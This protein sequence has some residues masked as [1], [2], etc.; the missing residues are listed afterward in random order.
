MRALERNTTGSGKREAGSEKQGAETESKK[1]KLG[2]GK[3]TADSRKQDEENQESGRG[4]P[5]R[6][7]LEVGSRKQGTGAKSQESGI[8]NR[9]L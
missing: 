7:T 1:K 6:V 5:G 8:R 4:E 3:W 9:E 2:S